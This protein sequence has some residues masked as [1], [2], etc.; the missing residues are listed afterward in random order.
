MRGAISHLPSN[1]A[2]QSPTVGRPIG[3]RSP[4]ATPCRRYRGCA[5]SGPVACRTHAT[6]RRVGVRISCRRRASFARATAVVRS[7]R[8][9]PKSNESGGRVGR[10]ARCL[11]VPLRRATAYPHTGHARS[12]RPNPVAA[13]SFARSFAVAVRRSDRPTNRRRVADCGRHSLG[14][15][16]SDFVRLAPRCRLAATARVSWRTAHCSG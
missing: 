8:S 4:L 15:V 12:R 5:A 14:R 1:L 3:N 11:P 6:P 10:R 13:R 7:D 2:R 16:A 9:P